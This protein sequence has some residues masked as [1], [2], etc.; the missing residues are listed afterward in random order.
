MLNVKADIVAISEISMMLYG[1][2]YPTASVADVVV[3][4]GVR[5]GQFL[6]GGGVRVEPRVEP[7]RE[8]S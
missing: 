3:V 7:S 8:I 2:F 6:A 5:R 4:G 1:N